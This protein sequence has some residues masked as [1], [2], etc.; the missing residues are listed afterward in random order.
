M[1]SQPILDRLVCAKH[2]F[3]TSTDVL[4]QGKP[5][6]AGMAVLA[7]QDAAEMVLRAI[8]EHIHAPAREAF[9]QLIDDIDKQGRGSL[10]HRSA[11]NQLNKARVNFKHVGLEPREEDVRKFRADMA[12]FFAQACR[13]FL[14][15]DFDRL[16]LT[17]LVRH[18]RSRN[19]LEAAEQALFQGGFEHAVEGSAKALRIFQ[20]YWAKG[21]DEGQ[22]RKLDL[23]VGHASSELASLA[24]DLRDAINEEFEHLHQKLEL[25]AQGVSYDDFRRFSDI[26]PTVQLS[27]AGTFHVM[28]FRRMDVDYDDALFCL[29]FARNLI[30]KVQGTYRSQRFPFRPGKEQYRLT[31]KADLIVYPPKDGNPP[32]IVDT[33]P[34][35]TQFHGYIRL[36]NLPGY[37]ALTYQDD[38]VYVSDAVVEAIPT[39]E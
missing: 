24:R 28:H 9:N 30:L 22:F 6:A 29:N 10:S 14:E 11:L 17:G 5:Y 20:H 39:S 31:E 19:W 38:C 4:S 26:T 18:R 27:G 12:V 15:L 34:P 36:S 33:A 35:G 7:L 25:L 2:L 32:E 16:S 8:A 23:R 13:T 37:V 21:D 3:D 1:V